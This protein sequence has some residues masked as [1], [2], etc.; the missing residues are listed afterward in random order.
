MAAPQVAIDEIAS[1]LQISH[2]SVY[3]IHDELGF[4]KLCE[5]CAKRAY[6]RAQAQTC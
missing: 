6:R 4:R 3:Q 1:S 2:G 5:M